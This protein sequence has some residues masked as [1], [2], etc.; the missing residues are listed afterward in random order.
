MNTVRSDDTP[1]RPERVDRLTFSR[2]FLC[3][4]DG[5]YAGTIGKRLGGVGHAWMKAYLT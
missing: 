5:L 2:V 1:A 3:R 4:R